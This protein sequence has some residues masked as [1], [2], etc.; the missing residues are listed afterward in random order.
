MQGLG[1]ST[2][3]ILV[4]TVMLFGL[5]TVP[6]LPG[7]VIIWVPALVY[8][9]STGFTWGSGLLFAGI[10]ALMIFGSVIDNI[11][12][13]ATARQQGASWWSIG[14]ALVAGLVGS[15]II[16]IPIIGGLI[17]ALLA[18]YGMEYHRLKDHKL[19]LESTRSMAIGCGWAALI[20]F[21]VGTI[22]I[23]MWVA[24]VIWL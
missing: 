12:M 4:L 17:A 23:L 8:G 18:L 21:A 19:A 7:L 14:A 16:P 15:F 9:I 6:I 13:G 24:W 11:V 5:F 22:M 10:T 1:E 3:N 2:L 20:R